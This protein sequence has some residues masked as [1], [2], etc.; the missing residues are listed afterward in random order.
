MQKIPVILLDIDGVLNE[1]QQPVTLCMQQKLQQLARQKDVYF[2]TGNTYTKSVDLLNGPIAMYAGIF[3]NNADELRGMRG[4]LIWQD[5]ETPPL[6]N[7]QDSLFCEASRDYINNC[8]E[9]RSPRFVN[10]CPVGRYASKEERDSHDSSWRTGF[11]SDLRKF[12]Y[13]DGVDGVWESIDC[14]IGGKVSID[15]YSKGA[16]KSRAAKWINDSGRNFVFIGDR[17]DEG[18]NDHCVKVYCDNMSQNKCLTSSGP[19]HTMEIINQLLG[20]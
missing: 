4:K 17:T 14:S 6:P 12:K 3:C 10:L 1:A 15:I 18:G 13:R 9:W 5:T 11:I 19:T 20:N 16:D 2:V 8:V 7:I